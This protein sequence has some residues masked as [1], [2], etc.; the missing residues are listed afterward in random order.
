MLRGQVC[1][2]LI[3]SSLPAHGNGRV[4]IK[5]RLPGSFDELLK[6]V[7]VLQLCIAIEKQRRVIGSV[8][9]MFM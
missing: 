9:T 4:N 8:L 5:V 7:Y 1:R 6:L 3:V 2:L